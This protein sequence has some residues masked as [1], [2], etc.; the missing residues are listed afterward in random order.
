MANEEGA[1]ARA[2]VRAVP[3]E[4]VEAAPVVPSELVARAPAP[5]IDE[6]FAELHE[7]IPRAAGV[8]ELRRIYDAAGRAG[9]RAW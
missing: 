4:I 5:P 9:V 1:P 7:L 6:W 8:E 2:V 3:A